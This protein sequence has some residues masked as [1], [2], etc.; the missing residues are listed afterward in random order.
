MGHA[1]CTS[2]SRRAIIAAVLTQAMI[3]LHALVRRRLQTR[4]QPHATT[5]DPLRLPHD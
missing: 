3:L 1:F 4:Q 5:C 2:I